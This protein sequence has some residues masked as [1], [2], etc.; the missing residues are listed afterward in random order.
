MASPTLTRKPIASLSRS[1]A[2]PHIHVDWALLAGVIALAGVGADLGNMSEESESS[3]AM[4]SVR[5]IAHEVCYLA[6]DYLF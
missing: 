2:D 3:S 1:H 5:A 6:C 4:H